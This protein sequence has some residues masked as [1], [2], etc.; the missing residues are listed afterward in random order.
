MVKGKLYYIYTL[1]YVVFMIGDNA[2]SRRAYEID[3]NNKTCKV[4]LNNK[5]EV[6]KWH[7]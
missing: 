6:I 5:Y 3:K 2:I 1:P 4:R 7:Y